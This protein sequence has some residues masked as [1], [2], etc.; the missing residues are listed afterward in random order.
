MAVR[1]GLLGHKDVKALSIASTEACFL[2]REGRTFHVRVAR[3]TPLHVWSSSAKLPTDV[4][5]EAREDGSGMSSV[6]GGDLPSPVEKSE[7]Q[8]AQGEKGGH[9]SGDEGE[10]DN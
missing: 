7:E 8:A 1:S 5:G 6:G 9:P 4:C 2:Y 3:E 10:D